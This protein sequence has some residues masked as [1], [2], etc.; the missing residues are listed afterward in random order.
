MTTIAEGVETEKQSGCSQVQGFLT[1]RPIP[2]HEAKALAQMRI[3]ENN[4]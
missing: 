2:A 1:G 4:A 3:E